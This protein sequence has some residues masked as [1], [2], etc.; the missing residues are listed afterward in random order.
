ME[1]KNIWVEGD[2]TVVTH[3]RYNADFVQWA[4]WH[5]G[6]WHPEDKTWRFEKDRLLDVGR[7]LYKYFGI[8][9]PSLFETVKIEYPGGE[10]E[11]YTSN[12]RS[13]VVVLGGYVMAWRPQ[14]DQPVILRRTEIVSGTFPAR[15]GSTNY[16][17]VEADGV[18][19]RS[20][21]PRFVIDQLSEAEKKGVKIYD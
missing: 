1:N 6:K 14:R 17:R 4:K 10:F 5:G 21:V 2:G 11:V 18:I 3:T 20:I 15:G 19:L 12:G 9:D 7:A 13:T 8:I 16:P